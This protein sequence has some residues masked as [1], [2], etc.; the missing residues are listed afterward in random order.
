MIW[1]AEQATALS[2]VFDALNGSALAWLVMRNYEGLPEEN[3]SK[4]IDLGFERRDFDRARQVV[5]QALARNG[6]DRVWTSNF[7]YAS[8]CVFF[9]RTGASVS[10]I[11]IDFLDGF[12]WRGAQLVAFPDLYRERVAYGNFF[13]PNEA[14][15]AFQL[16]MKPLL[17]GAFLKRTYVADIQRAVAR[18]PDEFNARLVETFG[19]DLAQELWPLL[20]SGRLQETVSFQR[21]LQRAGWLV[22]FRRRPAKTV[23]A[24]VE[25]FY[26]EILRRS[27]RNPASMVAVAGPDG[28]G[29]TT[30]IEH[31][32]KEMA[33]VMV[34]DEEVIVV[35]HFRPNVLPNIKKLLAGRK[36]DDKRE[37]FGKPHRAAAAG[38]ASSL[39]R[40]TYY[41]CDYV[42]GY[43]LFIRR[44]CAQHHVVIFD[45]YF[46]DFIVDPRRS[47]IDLPLWV[48]KIFLRL[49]PQPDLVFFLDCDA[50]I[51]F[52]RKQELTRD[53]IARQLGEYR[54]MAAA[55][56]ARFVR[57]DSRQSPEDSCHAAIVEVVGRS[58]QPQ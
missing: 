11:K 27:V 34:K 13:V 7:Q 43:W 55:S 38:R 9:K 49:T 52:A 44:K 45:R 8:C 50:D 36:Y 35:E 14:D 25:H 28:V 54:A 21:R 1:T 24:A 3:R 48:R 20:K 30:F 26:S 31:L 6:Y 18:Y 12:V 23:G 56:P 39:V 29:K 22:A 17:T 5:G 46:Y 32:R 40:L 4:D 41:W 2:S 47:R 37:E 53:E 19:S 58:F 33:R 10:S 15:D 42:L 51:V 16:W 57:L